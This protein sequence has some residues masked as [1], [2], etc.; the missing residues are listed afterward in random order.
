M[1]KLVILDPTKTGRQAEGGAK[2]GCNCKYGI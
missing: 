2:N 1:P